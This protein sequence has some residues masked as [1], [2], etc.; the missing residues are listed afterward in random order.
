M[1]K[2]K[3][4][5]A[6]V[7]AAVLCVCCLA[8]CGGGVEGTY[9]F[10]SMTVEGQTLKAG[11]SYMGIIRLSEEFVVLEL[12]QDGTCTMKSAMAEEASVE[13][14]WKKD[15]NDENKIVVT[16]EGES[17]TFTRNGKELSFETERTKVVLRK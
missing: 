17:T 14:T 11:E 8:A 13:G 7:I 16:A 12:K 10:N 2:L 6:A 15:E 4:C 5:L 3:V 1:K 9:K